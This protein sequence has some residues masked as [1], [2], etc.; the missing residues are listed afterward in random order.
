M[1]DKEK[2]H[3]V[4]DKIIPTLSR[5]EKNRVIELM[6]EFLK[7]RTKKI[8]NEELDTILLFTPNK[9]KETCYKLEESMYDGRM[10]SIRDIFE[11]KK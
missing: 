3:A 10:V 11:V 5:M 8:T 2:T 7:F 9:I 1:Y 6:G 4:A